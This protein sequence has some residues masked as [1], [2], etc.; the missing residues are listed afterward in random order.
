[1]DAENDVCIRRGSLVLWGSLTY[2]KTTVRS[3]TTKTIDTTPQFFIPL[4]YKLEF[5]ESSSI[6]PTCHK[7]ASDHDIKP[8]SHKC[9]RSIYHGIFVYPL[10]PKSLCIRRGVLWVSSNGIIEGF[11]D[12]LNIS[13]V[14]A[15]LGWTLNET[16]IV[17]AREP[18]FFFPGFVGMSLLL[19]YSSIMNISLF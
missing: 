15:K 9:K 13:A 7:M 6:S 19:M 4:G 18:G 8:E 17:E 1:M 2:T 12:T 5:F 10:T 14:A 3:G 16:V 11:S